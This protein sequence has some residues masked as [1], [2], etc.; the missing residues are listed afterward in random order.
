MYE[1]I[2]Y[3]QTDAHLK[4][5]VHESIFKLHAHTSITYPLS[6]TLIYTYTYT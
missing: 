5:Q 4:Q 3:T 2:V 6:I 1:Y